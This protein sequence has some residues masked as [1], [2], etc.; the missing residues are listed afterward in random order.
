MTL[1]VMQE[2]SANSQT[3][4]SPMVVASVFELSHLAFVAE[5]LEVFAFFGPSSNKVG[6]VVKDLDLLASSPISKISLPQD[7]GK[8][9]LTWT[10]I[11]EG[12]QRDLCLNKSSTLPRSTMTFSISCQHKANELF[13]VKALTC[14]HPDVIRSSSHHEWYSVMSVFWSGYKA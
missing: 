11:L 10:E 13:C 5:P 3:R 12:F 8:T 1:G 6:T 7:G 4:R 14:N 9:Q 2:F